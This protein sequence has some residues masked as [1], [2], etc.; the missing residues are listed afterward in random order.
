MKKAVVASLDLLVVACWTACAVVVIWFTAALLRG[1]SVGAVPRAPLAGLGIVVWCAVGGALVLSVLLIGICWSRTRSNAAEWQLWRRVLLA[2]LFL[3]GPTVYYVSSLRPAMLNRDASTALARVRGSRTLL[4]MLHRVSI[5]SAVAFAVTIGA[6][7]L[8]G[9][10]VES[11]RALILAALV[12]LPIVVVSTMAM[13]GILLVDV[14]VRSQSGDD[15]DDLR[16]LL[17]PWS[18][19]FRLRRYYVRVLRPEL[20]SRATG[21][22]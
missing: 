18:A 10:S 14:V 20:R 22:E 2:Q 12:L 7:L 6:L 16:A 15:Q 11:V 13:T 5:G 4:D 9:N 3:L 1:L 8:L 17:G 19:L 21:R